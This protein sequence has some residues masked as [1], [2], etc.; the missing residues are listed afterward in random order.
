MNSLNALA[1]D[2][3]GAED[4]VFG[5][6]FDGPATAFTG[7]AVSLTSETT[8]V[9]LDDGVD[10]FEAGA[11]AFAGSRFGAS[12]SGLDL[13]GVGCCAPEV[14]NEEGILAPAGDRK[15]GSKAGCRG[16]GF[17]SGTRLDVVSI[18]GR[19]PSSTLACSSSKATDQLCPG[20]IMTYLLFSSSPTLLP[21][22]PSYQ[23][24]TLP[25]C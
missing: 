8:G 16:N 13:V 19:H 15:T 17:T 18:P 22:E 12:G 21:L 4:L 7:L 20:H 24:T 9:G 14:C 6:K 3:G 10:F 1:S 5:L 11:G 2:F 25:R 23:P